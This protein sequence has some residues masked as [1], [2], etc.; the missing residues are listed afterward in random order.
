LWDYVDCRDRDVDVRRRR[1]VMVVWWWWW[2]MVMMGWDVMVRWRWWTA[3][4]M[5]VDVMRRMMRRMSLWRAMSNCNSNTGRIRMSSFA[6][7]LLA[8]FGTSYKNVRGVEEK[9]GK[10]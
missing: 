2:M 9:K 1:Y 10:F 8:E 4:G 7:L 6:L 5:W 3:V